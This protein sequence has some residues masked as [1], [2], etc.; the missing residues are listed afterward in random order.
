M[1]QVTGD[2]VKSKVVKELK[3]GGYVRVPRTLVQEVKLYP[4]NFEMIS[5]RKVGGQSFHMMKKDTSNPEIMNVILSLDCKTPLKDAI[6]FVLSFL[7]RGTKMTFKEWYEERWSGKGREDVVFEEY[8]GLGEIMRG[9][10]K[11]SG[12][13]NTPGKNSEDYWD[14]YA[15]KYGLDKKVIMSSNLVFGGVSKQLGKHLK[16]R[17]LKKEL[18]EEQARYMKQKKYSKAVNGELS[19]FI[20][21]DKS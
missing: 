21:D 6:S 2:F 20:L 17:K 4:S 5:M 13:E 9:G 15:E 3:K 19:S 7:G 1:S 14:L 10:L 11:I 8:P 12:G 18:E 16:G